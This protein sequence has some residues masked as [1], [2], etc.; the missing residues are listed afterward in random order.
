MAG[1]GPVSATWG[2]RGGH[3]LGGPAP[4]PSIPVLQYTGR[5]RQFSSSN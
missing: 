3:A 2:E 4:P 5:R 1:S